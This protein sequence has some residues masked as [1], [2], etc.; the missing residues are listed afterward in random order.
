MSFENLVKKLSP[1]LRG[2]T[3]KLDGRFASFNDEDLYQEALLYLWEQYKRGQIYGQTDSFIL[4]G[5][6][7]FLKN[8]I[9]KNYKRIDGCSVSLNC[10]I[11]GEDTILEEMLS[12]ESVD[13]CIEIIN[14]KVLVEEI[15]SRLTGREKKIFSLY[16]KGMTTR[17]I[18]EEIG[19][20]HVMVVK[21][22]SRIRNK[23]GYIKRGIV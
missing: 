5:C 1:K 18:G 20:S 6:F 22:K 10:P 2:I 17:E 3:R 16:L 8:Y 21:I 19:I 14:R 12:S 11:D 4:Q 23:C 13:T 15:H 9:R 7:L